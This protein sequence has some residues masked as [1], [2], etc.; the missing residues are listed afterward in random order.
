[1][2]T[3]CVILGVLLA[4]PF[5]PR[6]WRKIKQA[7]AARDPQNAPRSAASFWYLRFLKR[8]SREGFKKAPGQTPVEFAASIDD[9]ETRHEA[10]VFTEHYERARF[11]E[12]VEDAERLPQL[13]EEMAG[14]R[15]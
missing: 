1:M 11:D 7:R 12:S 8:L 14:R 15:K 9:P 10:V 4:L 2:A 5:L 13:Y 3:I 6:S